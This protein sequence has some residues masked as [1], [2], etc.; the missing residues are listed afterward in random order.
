MATPET[1]SGVRDIC[2]KNVKSSSRNICGRM[3][4][5]STSNDQDT[6]S[7]AV[8]SR[9]K[10]MNQTAPN[11]DSEVLRP[12]KKLRH[13]EAEDT[14]AP[15]CKKVCNARGASIG[16]PTNKHYVLACPAT[17]VK[18]NVIE[19]EDT[20]VIGFRNSH[21]QWHKE[22]HVVLPCKQMKEPLHHNEIKLRE[23][24]D[25]DKQKEKILERKREQQM[26][27]GEK[28]KRRTTVPDLR[29]VPSKGPENESLRKEIAEVQTESTKLSDEQPFSVLLKKSRSHIKKGV[30]GGLIRNNEETEGSS[31]KGNV[32][33]TV[34]GLEKEHPTEETTV[35][36]VE[37]TTLSSHTEKEHQPISVFLE[38]S[39][40]HIVGDSGG[41]LESLNSA[42]FN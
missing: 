30:V 33:D 22:Q 16:S 42:V 31:K 11:T 37:P 40:S 21:E 23:V 38:K 14:K 25:M 32:D 3:D 28:H 41:N 15:T 35:V 7:G 17:K 8:Y 39:S 9:K 24:G 13:G 5:Q 10:N 26:N 34:R 6:P 27:S 20:E 18:R 1:P 29:T 19:A 4:I 12:L 36:Q 2:W